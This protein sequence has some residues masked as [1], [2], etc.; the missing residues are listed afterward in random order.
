MV[1]KK[2]LKTILILGI[3]TLSIVPAF[4]TI[5]DADEGMYYKYVT[6]SNPS[7]DYSMWMNVTYESHMQPDFDDLRFFK[8]DNV[9]KLNYWIEKKS[10]SNY[11]W[12]W[13]NLS[14]DIESNQAFL[15][16][17]GDTAATS[18]SSGDD[19][20]WFFEDYDS[21]LS[22]YF[23]NYS[24]NYYYKK[25]G[26]NVSTNWRLYYKY[27]VSQFNATPDGRFLAIGITNTTN[28]ATSEEDFCGMLYSSKDSP[29]GA[30]NTGP[31]IAMKLNTFND[32]VFQ[33]YNAWLQKRITKEEPRYLDYVV[34]ATS[35]VC[36]IYYENRTLN[37]TIEDNGGAHPDVD[38][39]QR[40]YRIGFF[41]DGDFVQ[42]NRTDIDGNG[43]LKV[44]AHKV[45][46]RLEFMIDYLFVSKY[47]DTEPT[48]T[49][50]AETE[51]NFP[52][53]HLYGSWE[54]S[55]NI[56]D[57][58]LDENWEE[59]DYSDWFVYDRS[60]DWAGNYSY[61]HW[62]AT[63]KAGINVTFL[64]NS[65]I[66][67][68]QLL[69]NI[70]NNGSLPTY[71]TNS[72]AGYVIQDLYGDRMFFLQGEGMATYMIYY[73]ASTDDY[74]DV[75]SS[76]EIDITNVNVS[77]LTN[78]ANSA[79]SGIYESEGEVA[80]YYW[81]CSPHQA[82]GTWLKL[83]KDYTHSS[84][85]ES[86]LSFKAWGDQSWNGLMKEPAG[87]II[88]YYPFYRP[89]YKEFFTQSSKANTSIGLAV[90]NPEGEAV[91]WDFDVV[92]VF[93]ENYTVNTSRPNGGVGTTYTPYWEFPIINA[94]V[95]YEN[96][97]GFI[98]ETFSGNVSVESL[99]PYIRNMS[100]ATTK[101][102]MY[103]IP[104]DGGVDNDPWEQN[105]SVYLY[106]SLITNATNLGFSNNNILWVHIEACP[107]GTGASGTG[108]GQ[109]MLTINVDGDNTW[110]LNDRAYYITTDGVAIEWRGNK[111]Q[112]STIDTVA[113]FTDRDSFLNRH[114]YWNHSMFDYFIPTSQ[115]IKSN[116]KPIN[117]SDI[118]NISIF[119]TQDALDNI[120]YIQSIGQEFYDKDTLNNFFINTTGEITNQS[121]M[122]LTGFPSKWAQGQITGYETLNAEYEYSYTVEKTVN[123]TSVIS[124][125]TTWH[126]NYSIWINNTGTGTLTNIYVNDTW[127]ECSCSDFKWSIDSINIANSTYDDWHNAS[128]YWIIHN[129]SL[130]IPQG[131]SW[132]IWY[133]MN[134]TNCTS[135]YLHGY[136]YNNITVNCS[137]LPQA[138]DSVLTT[139]GI[140][141][142]Y[143]IIPYN[144]QMTD[145]IGI[146][147]SVFT[148]IGV[149]LVIG[150][151]LLIIGV[152]RKYGIS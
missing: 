120:C 40:I 21:A 106:T 116:N 87:C 38:S 60:S 26:T 50:G 81:N 146:G 39:T 145:V 45:T 109:A 119:V 74:W 13:V 37:I 71:Y 143:G 14:D 86:C 77:N 57:G 63:G 80:N 101:N 97:S 17:Y 99:I 83:I 91:A 94:S 98:N 110:D 138:R 92:Q 1:D 113:R 56:A 30:N 102:S 100:N 46:D 93:Q 29:P 137:E 36:N 122:N 105:D 135:T 89:Y 70:H 24:A 52:A 90:W 76:K 49:F 141:G 62:D 47:I 41:V 147:N 103:F 9:T 149:M 12:V 53:S 69:M 44:G 8:P 133:V 42:W 28:Y 78:W 22:G 43:Y 64:N 152:V 61:R 55:E 151:I 107:F 115:L 148:I 34:N 72:S 79:P 140:Y 75:R 128:C 6:V 129:D 51:T 48:A 150:S 20:F 23:H 124:N 11:A 65:G 134:V 118:F 142:V 7:N 19:T 104:D 117:Q 85:D 27:N 114:R 82:N 5:V 54:F 131:E 121:Y 84:T 73:N 35:P 123:T 4:I 10:D 32:A 136:L 88:D 125:V 96:L 15:M 130:T 144:I 126:L 2:K 127:H 108:D 132:H 66:K 139:F 68:F 31:V 16:Y 3:L 33:G 18:E 67:S 59:D 112:V 95:Y 111:P 58:T 25:I